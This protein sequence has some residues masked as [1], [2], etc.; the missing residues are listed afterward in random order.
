LFVDTFNYTVRIKD[1]LIIIF[2]YKLRHYLF[3]CV[4]QFLYY[5]VGY[6]LVNNLYLG[7]INAFYFIRH[8]FYMTVFKVYGLFYDLAMMSHRFVKLVIL[9]PFRKAYWFTSFQYD[10]RLKKYFKDEA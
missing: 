10:K 9:Y 3:F 6:F 1:S 5:K 8:R 2:V 7:L 4:G